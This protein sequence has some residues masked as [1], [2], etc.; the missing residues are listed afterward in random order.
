M[1]LT[2]FRSA[3]QTGII[4]KTLDFLRTNFALSSSNTIESPVPTGNSIITSSTSTLTSS[5]KPTQAGA[6]EPTQAGASEPTQARA[7]EP[8]Q[9]GASKPIQAGATELTQ[10]KAPKHTS[11]TSLDVGN[12]S[13]YFTISANQYILIY[14]KLEP[15]EHMQN[16][17]D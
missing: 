6:S 9:A 14:L 16:G 4:K 1:V 13:I 5:S 7:S 2:Y 15:R 17:E 11:S 10:A 8:T 3:D 12:T